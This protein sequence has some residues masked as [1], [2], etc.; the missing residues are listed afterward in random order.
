MQQ[1]ELVD[2]GAG[3]G[4]LSRLLAY[5]LPVKVLTIEGD[6]EVLFF[7]YFK[8]FLFFGPRKDKKFCW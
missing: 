6:P 4:H 1:L 7:L 3:L 2:V 5:L 8:F